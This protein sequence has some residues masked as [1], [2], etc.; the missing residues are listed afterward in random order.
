MC[1]SMNLF[2]FDS[3]YI[4]EMTVLYYC[5]INLF[6][7]LFLRKHSGV[8]FLEIIVNSIYLRMRSSNFAFLGGIK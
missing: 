8:A 7:Y 5:T 4:L 3:S 2:A 6:I 1:A